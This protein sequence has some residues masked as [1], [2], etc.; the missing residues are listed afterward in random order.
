MA[1]RLSLESSVAGVIAKHPAAATKAFRKKLP[2]AIRA[3]LEKTFK[4]WHKTFAKHHFQRQ[5]FSRYPD[6]YG[7]NFKKNLSEKLKYQ[8]SK[9]RNTEYPL[10][11]TGRMLAAFAR[12][13]IIFTGSNYNL[14][15]NFKSLPPYAYKYRPNQTD[16]QKA[17]VV[18]N[19]AETV[20]LAKMFEKFLV[21]ELAK[22]DP[23]QKTLGSAVI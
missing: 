17:M 20:S 1:E 10:V 15:A 21:I 9:G 3:A 16:K 19:D 11:K 2:K 5:A 8:I 22:I 7:K 6:L 13:T 23:S 18:V 4:Y 14:N 12:G